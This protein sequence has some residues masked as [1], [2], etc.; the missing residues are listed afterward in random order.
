MMAAS[1]AV[2]AP[3]AHTVVVTLMAG[4]SS[5]FLNIGS[6]PLYRIINSDV[7]AANRATAAADAETS[8][9]AEAGSGNSAGSGPYE[10]VTY[11]QTTSCDQGQSG[12][13]ARQGAIYDIVIKHTKDAVT[14]AQMLESGDA[15][16]A[17]QIDPDT[18]KT[19]KTDN[20]NVENYSVLQLPVCGDC[21]RRQGR[22]E[23]DQVDPP[24]V[25]YALDYDGIIEFTSAPGHK[26]PTPIRTAS[27]G[28]ACRSRSRIWRRR[29]NCSP[30]PAFRTA[31][32]SN[33]SSEHELYGVDLSL[34]SRRSSRIW[35]RR[36]QGQT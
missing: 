34:L 27:L 32:R 11:S 13:Q 20:L 1:T 36:D 23:A 28:S 10:L 3:E 7:A 16:I 15:D 17:M 31:S 14:Q 4:P 19:L 29:R 9:K 12:V 6:A 35:P 26:V 2:E 33:R 21:A 25:G 18:A 5:E 24:G 8:D 22:A 30:R